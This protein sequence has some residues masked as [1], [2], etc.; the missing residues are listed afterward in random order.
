M[1]R[2]K[3]LRKVIKSDISKKVGEENNRKYPFLVEETYQLTVK[4]PGDLDDIKIIVSCI[5][6]NDRE[7]ECSFS[8]LYRPVLVK[9][10]RILNN[11]LWNLPIP[12]LILVSIYLLTVR[13]SMTI[14]NWVKSKALH[15]KVN[16][17]W[18]KV[19]V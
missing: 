2:D 6:G 18:L 9:P 11:R 12:V 3:S 17:S 7:E 15:L 5:T 14:W 13:E 16:L 10:F 8:L 19:R 4:L 1:S